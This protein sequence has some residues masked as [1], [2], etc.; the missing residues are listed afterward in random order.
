MTVGKTPVD[1]GLTEIGSV[2]DIAA[3]T[4]MIP[5]L[6]IYPNPVCDLLMIKKNK[7]LNGTL[8]VINASGQTIFTS[9]ALNTS[10]MRL[11]V[12]DWA[13][14][15]YVVEFISGKSVFHKEIVRD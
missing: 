11:N 3:F 13:K 10:E 9:S 15:L 1:I 5:D 14:G 6:V 2:N 12:S 8:R 4:E 7:F